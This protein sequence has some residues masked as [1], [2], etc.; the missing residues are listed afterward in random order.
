MST[1][2]LPAGDNI[3]DGSKEPSK[4]A[5]T[6]ALPT[7]PHGSQTY[8]PPSSPPI[9]VT[10]APVSPSV[11]P[12]SPSRAAEGASRVLSK[13]VALFPGFSATGSPAGTLSSPTH[14]FNP[15]ADVSSNLPSISIANKPSAAATVQRLKGWLVPAF[16]D[17]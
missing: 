3:S 1:A 8:K 15:D 2:S 9:R 16:C 5:E 13:A 4:N 7:L 14:I 17:K 6:A 12:P 10:S 11:P